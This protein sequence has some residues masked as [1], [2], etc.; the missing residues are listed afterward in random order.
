MTEGNI[1]NA[2]KGTLRMK[3]PN[4]NLKRLIY[5]EMFILGLLV[6]YGIYVLHW[7]SDY[8]PPAIQESYPTNITDINESNGYLCYTITAQGQNN[9]IKKAVCKKIQ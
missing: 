3:D 4:R 5:L 6:G 7:F 9:Y 2:H 8:V 1:E